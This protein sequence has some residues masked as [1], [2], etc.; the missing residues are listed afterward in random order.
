MMQ[1]GSAQPMPPTKAGGSDQAVMAFRKVLGIP[2]GQPAPEKMVI[3]A[4]MGKLG[5]DIKRMAAAVG[6]AASPAAPAPAEGAPDD[7]Q[8]PA[9]SPDAP[10]AASAPRMGASAIFGK[11]EPTPPEDEPQDDEEA[12]PRARQMFGR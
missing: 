7:S 4:C 11:G 1:P 2:E 3:E 6:G 9:P 5:P 10:A 8:A 12:M